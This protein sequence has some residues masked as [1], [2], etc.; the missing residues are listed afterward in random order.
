MTRIRLFIF[1]T[2]V[3]AATSIPTL[4]QT[5]T[6][7][8]TTPPAPGTPKIA[9]INSEAFYDEKV[10]VTKLANALKQLEREF[11]PKNQELTA[12]NNRLGAISTELRNMQNLPPEQIN[13]SAFAAKREEGERLKREF[14]Y[15]KAEAENAV[16]KRRSE[17]VGPISQEIGRAIDEY[18]KKH[19][20]NVIL[21]PSKLGESML[22]YGEAADSTRDFVVFFN[23]KSPAAPAVATPR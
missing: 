22:F 21:D 23:A 20:F 1:T 2:F 10:G 15:K 8:K 3:F 6:P 18:A 12:L 4:A 11:T 19:G 7:P 9:F 5:T 13:Q 14:D 16:A 17:L